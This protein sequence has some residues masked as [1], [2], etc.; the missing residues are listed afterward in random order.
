VFHKDKY[1]T[2][3]LFSQ[4]GQ[5]MSIKRPFFGFTL[6]EL[7][8]VIAI[9]GILIALLLP[10][11]QAAREAA[12]RMQCTNNEK[13]WALAMHNF[14]NTHGTLPPHG[15]EYCEG[16]VSASDPTVVYNKTDGGTGALARILPFVEAA[17]VSAGR[18]FSISLFPGPG[19]SINSYY[20]DVKDIPLS[21]L[22]CPS[23]GERTSGS[24]SP[25]A[26]ST[27]SGNYVV[28][29]G[30]GTGTNSNAV[31]K[32]DGAFYKARNAV[33]TK[34]N[35]DHGFESMTDGTSNTMVLSEALFGNSAIVGNID[36][37]GMDDTSKAKIF[38]RT[39][40]DGT[41]TPA[42][43]AGEN[44]DMVAFS[45]AVTKTGGKQER[46]AFW[47]SCRWD[48]S[49]YNGYLT[50]NQKNAANYWKK[51]SPQLSFLKAASSHTGGVNVAYGDG[52]VHFTSDSVSR[53]VWANLSTVGN[54]LTE[55]DFQ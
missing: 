29:V 23:D 43:D 1:L 49:V 40:L 24:V 51:G 3:Q 4:K 8:V 32:T 25:T 31:N 16:P 10:A 22:G 13:Q 50:P 21:I 52:S 30:S 9:I 19:S 39:I 53:L 46:C 42:A 15:T 38:Q 20:S 28:C 27:A 18:D 12:R 35:G 36:L 48:H 44:E 47:L 26:N 37:A 41:Q 55:D 45:A 2:L 54:E 5:N 14:H 11:V 7:L 34:T 33:G 17:N 6:V